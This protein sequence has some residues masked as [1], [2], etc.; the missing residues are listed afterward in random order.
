VKDNCEKF[1]STIKLTYFA[2][3]EITWLKLLGLFGCA[4]FL[5]CIM[6]FFTIFKI[7]NIEKN[8]FLKLCLDGIENLRQN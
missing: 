5:Y 7:A 4:I 3:K 8:C 1:N 2:D 6:L